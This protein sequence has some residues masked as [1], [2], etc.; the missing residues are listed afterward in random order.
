[1]SYWLEHKP[2]DNLLIALTEGE[3]AWDD[4]TGHVDRERTTALPSSLD[5]AFASE[6][7]WI[8]LR[9][10]RAQ[11]DVSLR[12]PD[13]RNAVADLAAPIHGRDKDTLLGDD[14]SQH[15]RAMRLARAAVATLVALL[16]AASVAAFLAFQQR[17]A[18]RAGESNALAGQAVSTL[19]TDP[20][21]ALR[22]ARQAAE[23][24]PTGAA[25]DALRLTLGHVPPLVL[26]GHY[27]GITS[28]AFSTDGKRV[29]T[30]GGDNT[31]RIWDVAS[32][33]N[34]ETLEIEG[35]EE[36]FGGFA[37][38]SRTG[39]LAVTAGWNTNTAQVWDVAHGGKLLHSLVTDD[40]GY[41]NSV[42]TLSPDGRLVVTGNTGTLLIWDVASGRVRH[43]LVK[44]YGTGQDVYAASFSPDGKLLVTAGENAVH[45][46][47]VA[48]GRSLHRLRGHKGPVR[49][50]VFSPDGKLVVTVAEDGTARVWDAAYGRLLRTIEGVPSGFTSSAA[51]SPDDRLVLT[52]GDP[53]VRISAACDG[54]GVPLDE[55]LPRA[56]TWLARHG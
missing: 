30:T 56:N 13:F 41:D 2:R 14:I 36:S 37:S 6:P 55:L 18:A 49:S 4:S 35:A 22:L 21:A 34:L 45:V 8:D 42:A 44:S 26:E 48:S 1:M 46:W 7:F 27:K 33:R 50:A 16:I 47:D 53:W 3:I 38:L 29:I 24:S 43:T 10:A 11:S 23:T 19:D 15:R 51:I 25:E 52:V 9:F 32:G 40:S 12:Q 20:V 17:N 31:A 5:T 28:Q 39:K 54:C